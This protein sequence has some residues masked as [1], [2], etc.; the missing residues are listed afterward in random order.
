MPA[1]VAWKEKI[2]AVVADDLALYAM[3]KVKATDA[4]DAL[5]C[6]V[7][8]RRLMLLM[9]ADVAWNWEGLGGLGA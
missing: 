2:V 9:L 7:S 5:R 4:A 1:G 8:F 3:G 6:R